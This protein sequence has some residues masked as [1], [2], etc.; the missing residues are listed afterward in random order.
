YFGTVGAWT[1]IASIVTQIFLTSWVLDKLGVKV[2]LSFL[3]VSIFFTS[4]GF[5]IFPV[6]A[7]ATA[8][9]SIT[10]AISYSINQSSKD[11][12][13]TPTPRDAIYKAKAFIDMFVQR[14]AKAFAV[15]LN[16]AFVAL[17]GA[18]VRWLSVLALVLTTGYY[19]LIAY[20]GKE[21]KKD[22]GQVKKAA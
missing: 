15:I 22:E 7:M 1:G 16:L 2:A 11:A 8:M 4:L 5:L 3:P 10:N 14:F 21:F 17:I 20:V 6:L 12:L 9:S 18:N 19:G 13:Y